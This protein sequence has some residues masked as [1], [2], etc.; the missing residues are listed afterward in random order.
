MK[1]SKALVKE[2]DKLVQQ[3][4]HGKGCYFCTMPAIYTHHIIRR[5]DDLLRHDPINLLPVCDKCHGLI[6]NGSLN[7]FRYLPEW[8][9]HELTRLKRVSYKDYLI[10]E[11]NMTEEEYLREQRTKLREK[12]SENY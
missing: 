1:K 4:S 12:V 11:L 2:L 6:H 9:V 10:F 3:L 8:R 7:E 5:D